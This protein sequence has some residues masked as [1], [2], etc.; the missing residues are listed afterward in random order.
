MPIVKRI[1]N[2]PA[3]PKELQ[4]WI[5]IG[6][7][8]LKA[9]IEA[10]KA[11]SKLEE[12]IAAKEAALSDTQDLAEELLYA[13]ARLGEMLK[14]REKQV[15][16]SRGGT[17]KPLPKDINKKQSHEA[18]ELHRH[19]ETIAEVVAGAREK[20]EIPVRQHVLN[21]IKFPHVSQNTGQSEWF[22]PSEYIEKARKIMGSI[23]I[24]PATTE[25]AN[26]KIK[27][28]IIYTKEKSGIDKVWKGNVWMNPPYSQPLISEFCGTF[29]HNWID[30]N[31][32]Q[33]MILINNATETEFAQSLLKHCSVVCFPKGRVRFLDENEK[34]GA[35]LQG[36]ML[37]YFG[38][39]LDS[40]IKEFSCIGICLVNVGR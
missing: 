8:K 20:G 1:E 22:T 38:D 24:D 35:P 30:D 13:E 39:N 9:Q 36:Q 4:K 25:K 28:S 31:I 16:S 10:I 12:G 26:K 29:L 23:D 33:G 19:E 15:R 17:S 37:I 40:F 2:L 5:L 32:K 6:K 7:A 11:I 34:P 27:A 3:K 18:Q 14:D 21:K